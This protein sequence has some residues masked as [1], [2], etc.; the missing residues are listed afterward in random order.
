MVTDFKIGVLRETGISPD[1]RV[2]ITPTVAAE[3]LNVYKGLSICVQPSI[4]RAFDDE[5]YLKAGCLLVDDLSDC[6][7]LLGVKEVDPSMLIPDRKYMFF[8]HTAKMQPHNKE[9]LK[10]AVTNK[11]TLI[12]YEFLV[13][14]SNKRLVAFGYWA[15]LIGAYCTIRGYGMKENLFDLLPL[16]YIRDKNHLFEEL[17]HVK[18]LSGKFLVTGG[19]RVASGV[20][21]VFNALEIKAV[22]KEDFLIKPYGRPVYF[23]AHPH[24]Y[25]KHPEMHS[26]SLDYFI[27]YP[28][29]FVSDFKKFIPVT[30]VLITGHYWNPKSPLFFEKGDLQDPDFR[31]SF[32]G[33]I[34]CDI[35]GPIPTT[36]RTSRIEEP[37]YDVDRRLQ[38]EQLAF[39]DHN[40]ITVMAID[41]LPSA[42]PRDSSECF[43]T[44][45]KNKVLPFF[46][47]GDFQKVIKRA[48]IIRN[49]IFTDSFTYLED[50]IRNDY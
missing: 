36:L 16:S 25:V 44:N 26:F 41:Q 8:S 30:D 31:L 43:S 1:R 21:E 20:I 14:K 49:G 19:G 7:L 48:T 40:N 22:S 46:W 42:L 6:D 37:F 10:A 39:S 13:D 24:S 34:S 50:F 11:I 33:D 9:L 15:G 5:E 17:R 18:N 38:K 23:Q 32:I 35:P 28:E 47:E 4:Y 27:R 2:A 3:L 45:L 29:E 12:D